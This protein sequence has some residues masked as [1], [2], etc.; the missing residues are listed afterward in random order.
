MGKNLKDFIAEWNEIIIDHDKKERDLWYKHKEIHSHIK[1]NFL[2]LNPQNITTEKL[3][4]LAKD[5]RRWYLQITETAHKE[6]LI[7][8]DAVIKNI[9]ITIEQRPKKNETEKNETKKNEITL[10]TIFRD[11]N[12]KLKTLKFLIEKKVIHE[13]TYI[14]YHEKITIKNFIGFIK[15]LHVKGYLIARPTNKEVVVICGL[16]GLN[17]KYNT[18]I[19]VSE[20][21]TRIKIMPMLHT[22]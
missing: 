12:A 9:E 4:Q 1:D 10:D 13:E 8:F 17:T 22:D 18:V 6:F 7:W 16:F 2:N 14:F 5:Y 3:K 11:E 19:Q 21:D 20:K 15:S